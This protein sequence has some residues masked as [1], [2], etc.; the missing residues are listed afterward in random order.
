M[1]AINGSAFMKNMNAICEAAADKLDLLREKYA[2]NL[3]RDLESLKRKWEMF[4]GSQ[5]DIDILRSI[6]SDIH[7]LAGSGATFGFKS[8]SHIAR[9]LENLIRKN[10]ENETALED[11]QYEQVNTLLQSLKEA[12]DSP[13]RIDS[14]IEATRSEHLQIISH[15]Q[16][17][18]ETVY[19]VEESEITAAGIACQLKSFGY[20]SMIFSDFNKFISAIDKQAPKVVIMDVEYMRA[21]GNAELFLQKQQSLDSTITL[22]ALSDEGN[23][24]TRLQAVR[25]GADGF[26]LKPVDTNDLVDKLDSILVNKVAEPY[27]VMIIDDSEYLSSHYSLMLQ[28]VGMIT[29]IVNNPMK[30][31]DEMNNFNPELVLLDINMPQCTGL[32][33]A[34]VIRHQKTYVG[35]P[36]VYLSAETDANRQIDAM[37][38]GGDEFLTK[39]I[40]P[41]QL[42]TTITNR[43]R[44]SRVLRS[45][46]I[47][48]GLTG[49]LNHTRT[50]EMLISEVDRARRRNS[51][52][53]YAMIDIDNF[54]SV[55]D[56]FGHPAGDRI[57]KQLANILNQ[58]LRNTDII[59]RY[60][61]EEFAIVLIDTDINTAKSVLDEIR[62]SFYNMKHVEEG[63]VFQVSFSCGIAGFPD[64]KN[65][66]ALNDAADK[67]L[68]HAKSS[69]KNRIVLYQDMTGTR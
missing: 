19:I 4:Y 50:K 7:R 24:E 5:S 56:Q 35:I 69:G 30:V 61:G 3:P 65:A 33:L 8:L 57:I 36:I 26:F 52:M 2:A 39:P 12:A 47:R 60:G 43:I 62:E 37:S 6:Y 13:E 14:V 15:N 22:L 34:K 1:L 67:S 51:D 64:V 45:Y 38:I 21:S 42:L 17:C 53:C 68:Y 59:G 10:V 29:R 9:S 27:R 28:Q 41:V 23:L 31:L 46:M 20:G 11:G 18:S 55:N 44:R 49:L 25:H 63:I 32:E 54:K 58:R 48:D 16:H 66:G 40:A